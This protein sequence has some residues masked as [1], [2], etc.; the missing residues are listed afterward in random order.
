M[1]QANLGHFQT[2]MG[3]HGLYEHA[4][5]EIPNPAEGYCT[6]D[7]ARAVTVLEQLVSLLTGQDKVLAQELLARCWKFIEEA[8]YKPGIFY[9]LRE[10][11]GSWI[12]RDMASEDMYARIVQAIAA[13]LVYDQDDTRRT[14]AENIFKN[15]HPRLAAL[16][17]PRAIAELLV[18]FQKFPAPVQEKF[19]LKSLAQNYLGQLKNL[20]EKSS[21]PDWP[22]F[23]DKMTYANAILPHGILAGM[24]ITYD[25]SL[26]KILHAAADFLIKTTIPENIFIPIG[27]RGWYPRGGKPSHDNQQPIEAAATFDFLL[28]YHAA[29]PDRLSLGKVAAPYLWFFG[30]NTQQVQIARPDIGAAHDGLFKEGVNP[31]F[32]AESML[33][34]LWSEIR[35]AEAPTELQEYIRREKQ[36]LILHPERSRG[37]HPSITPAASS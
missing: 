35:L 20:W 16:T 2:M 17:A 27:S 31:N 5:V 11:D 25:N 30:A 14:S 12:E 7:N 33:A 26:E 9:N 28:D 10:S 8:E 24:K 37:A 36:K 19:T 22:W 4:S 21:A 29:Y 18:A 3:S 32:G 15:I 23:E 34:Y 1:A 13:V 6:D